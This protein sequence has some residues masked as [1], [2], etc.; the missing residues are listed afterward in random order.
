MVP[1]EKPELVFQEELPAIVVPDPVLPVTDA[2]PNNPDSLL[3]TAYNTAEVNQEIATAAPGALEAA[4]K[5]LVNDLASINSPVIEPKNDRSKI[6]YM[7]KVLK[8]ERERPD[9]YESM[10]QTPIHSGFALPHSTPNQPQPQSNT[11][12]TF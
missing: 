10:H 5:V 3:S 1:L 8:N 7:E 9:F 6:D 12:L 11:H 2:L 4:E